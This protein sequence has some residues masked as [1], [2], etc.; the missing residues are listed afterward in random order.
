MGGDEDDDD[1]DWRN[2]CELAAKESDTLRLRKLLDQLIERLD[3]RRKP[4]PSPGSAD[5]K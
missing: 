2:L 4:K 1:E 5:N 3:A